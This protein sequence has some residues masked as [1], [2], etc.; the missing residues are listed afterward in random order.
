VPSTVDRRIVWNRL[1]SWATEVVAQGEEIHRWRS[2]EWPWTLRRE[3]RRTSS[4]EAGKQLI[5]AVT[6]PAPAGPGR[7]ARIDYEYERNGMCNSDRSCLFVASQRLGEAPAGPDLQS[8]HFG[9][10]PQRSR[11]RP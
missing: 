1:L 5:G 11:A 3:K 6:I 7:P 2:S 8:F 4:D 10:H 9:T